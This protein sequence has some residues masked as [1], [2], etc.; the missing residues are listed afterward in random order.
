MHKE[1]KTALLAGSTIVA[2]IHP[3]DSIEKESKE[4]LPSFQLPKTSEEP[5]TEPPNQ[6]PETEPRRERRRYPFF[7]PQ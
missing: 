2:N 5:E 4:T 1:I 7:S 6:R 3:N